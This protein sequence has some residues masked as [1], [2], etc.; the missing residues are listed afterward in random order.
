[1]YI[2]SIRRNKNYAPSQ[3]KSPRKFYKMENY[4]IQ[5]TKPS[6]SVKENFSI[7]TLESISSQ[8]Y[9]YTSITPTSLNFLSPLKK[10]IKLFVLNP[11]EQVKQQS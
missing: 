2:R 9:T 1:M 8:N 6:Q 11:P 3:D 10:W 7:Y 4:R 5:G